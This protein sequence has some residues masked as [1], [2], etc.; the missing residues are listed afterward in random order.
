[1]PNVDVYVSVMHKYYNFS[2]HHSPWEFHIKVDPSMLEVFDHLFGQLKSWD[3]DSIWRA[4][5]PAV[6]YHFDQQND[7]VDKRLMKLYAL[8]HEYGDKETKKFIEQMPYY[9]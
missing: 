2:P 4:Q 3:N 1:M 5:I 6:P 8:I 7:E 9:S